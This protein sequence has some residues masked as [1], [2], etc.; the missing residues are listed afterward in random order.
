M[1]IIWPFRPFYRHSFGNSIAMRIV[2]RSCSFPF[3]CFVCLCRT[4]FIHG[5][6]VHFVCGTFSLSRIY[7]AAMQI[8]ESFDMIHMTIIL[9]LFYSPNK[10]IPL[11]LP[12]LFNLNL[13]SMFRPDNNSAFSCMQT[14]VRLYLLSLFI[15]FQFC[16]PILVYPSR[17]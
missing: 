8:Q 13:R 15:H 14:D 7:V 6:I 3:P 12:I 10:T 9:C 1:V 16:F 2:L 5:H 4:S 17:P 11:F